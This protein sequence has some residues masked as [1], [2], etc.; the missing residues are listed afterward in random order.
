MAPGLV[1][2]TAKHLKTSTS[3]WSF[4]GLQLALRA[5]GWPLT[6]G[7][8]SFMGCETREG[9]GARALQ[10]ASQRD[11]TEIIQLPRNIGL[12]QHFSWAIPHS[13]ESWKGLM[14]WLGLVVG[15]HRC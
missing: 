5:G 1:G 3:N 11:G 8:W 10:T 12:Y 13:H 4:M 9:R 15:C 14:S 2:Q 7:K 6:Q